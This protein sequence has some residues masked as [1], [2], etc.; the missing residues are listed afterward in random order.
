[1]L[2]HE[3]TL[4]RDT[5]IIIKIGVAWN[6]FISG[7][8]ALASIKNLSLD[9]WVDLPPPPTLIKSNIYPSYR[10][11]THTYRA[12][13]WLRCYTCTRPP[14]VRIRFMLWQIQVL[15]WMKINSEIWIRPTPI[16]TGSR[17]TKMLIINPICV[18]NWERKGVSHV[19]KSWFTF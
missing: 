3:R 2:S 9:E 15:F 4:H 5:V 14:M 13:E 1:M 7:V 16:G 10:V 17:T 12:Y 11:H 18:E 6:G 8:L 19:N